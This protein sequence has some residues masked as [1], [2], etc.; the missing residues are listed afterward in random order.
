MIRQTADEFAADMGRLATEF[1]GDV[2]EALEECKPLVKA[3]VQANFD[4]AAAGDGGAWPARKDPTKTHPLLVLT[5]AL[6]AAAA[7]DGAGHVERIVSHHTL[8]LGVDKSAGDG[9]VPGAGVHQ[10]GYGPVLARPFL[11]VRSE[12]IDDCTEILADHAL[13]QIG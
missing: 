12:T 4:R 10:F 3:D 2:S 7:G 5:G 8:E 6:E 1:G 9:G 13:R 11:A